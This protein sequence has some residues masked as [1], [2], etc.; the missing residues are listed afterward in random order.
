MISRYNVVLNGVSLSSINE[1]ILVRDISHHSA[2]VRYDTFNVANRNGARIYKKSHATASVRIFFEI[3]AYSISDRQDICDAVCLWAKDGGVLCT[4][5]RGEKFLQCV[6]TEFP[7]VE[8]AKNWTDELAIT[9]T[10]YAIPFWQSLEPVKLH[11]NDTL[12]SGTMIV[13]GN[14]NNIFVEATVHALDSITSIALTVNGR[15]L[16]LSG[17]S[18]A[19]GNNVVVSYNTDGIQSIKNGT[20]SLLDKRSGVDDLLVNCGKNNSFS[21]LANGSA[22]VTYKVRGWWL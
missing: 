10:A 13:P 12:L 6:C 11:L 19:P 17:I 3:H 18:V 21:F 7:S 4:N 22:S 1:Q 20:T 8:S 5:D 14:V 15:T 9:F 2:D 16:T